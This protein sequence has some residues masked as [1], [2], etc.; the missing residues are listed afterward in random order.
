MKLKSS[1]SMKNCG[2]LTYFYP[3]HIQGSH[4]R[5]ATGFVIGAF[6]FSEHPISSLTAPRTHHPLIEEAYLE[7]LDS[8][9]VHVHSGAAFRLL[10]TIVTLWNYSP[11][12][13]INLEP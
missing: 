13:S 7:Y 4:K 11:D 12:L 2:S 10:I 5:V 8:K 6:Q 3:K 1:E 9:G